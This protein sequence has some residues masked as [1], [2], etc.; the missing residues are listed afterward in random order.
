MRKLVLAMF[1]SLDGYV[2]GPNREF[3]PPAWSD[4]VARHWSGE[5]L[6]MAGLLVYGR[7]NY[8]FNKDFWLGEA[9]DPS[10]PM[11]ASAERINALP[12]IVLSSTLERAEWNARPVGGDV[13][14][15]MNRL[16]AEPGKDLVCFGGAGAAGTLMRLGLVDRYRLM[17]TPLLLGGGTPLFP[18]G[19]AR[20]ALTLRSAATLDTGAVILDYERLV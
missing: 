19:L 8:E 20:Q 13:A 7:A 1:L 2:E 15:E 12:K 18:E 17:V 3:V 11:R 6:E 9:A 5:N 10:S 4:D 16:K 14:A